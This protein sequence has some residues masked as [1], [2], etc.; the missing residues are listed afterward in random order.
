MKRI[1]ALVLLV[2]AMFTLSSCF[3]LDDVTTYPDMVEYT[4]EQILDVAKNKYNIEEWIFDGVELK[5]EAKND[6]SNFQVELHTDRFGSQFVDGD[7]IENALQAFAG[8]NGNNYVQAKYS[9]FLCFVTLGKCA[10]NSLKY[11]YYNVNIHKNAVIADTIGASKYVFDVSPT[12]ITDELFDVDQKWTDMQLFMKNCKGNH[13]KGFV[14]SGERLTRY[15][16]TKYYDLSLEFYK[17]NGNVVC[18]MYYSNEDATPNE[19]TLFYST[20]NKYQVVYNYYGSDATQYF[21]ISH[22][23]EQ[24][25]GSASMMLL[26]GNITLKP[27]YGEVVFSQI[28]YRAEY[29]AVYDGKIMSRTDSKM[30]INQTTINDE[31]LIDKIDGVNHAETAQFTVYDY[32]ILYEKTAAE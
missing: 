29:D 1:F 25:S 28:K 2:V 10:D 5:G 14:Y 6:G 31:W 12:E 23:V 26:S 27:S 17:E 18:D 19:K 22:T 7:N 16:S 8:K 24:S 15:V 30:A 11:V 20:S 32:Y 13:A 4:A 3:W 21:N 9:T